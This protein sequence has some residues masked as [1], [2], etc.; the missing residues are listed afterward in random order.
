MTGLTYGLYILLVTEI[1]KLT[2]QELSDSV[3]EETQEKYQAMLQI[4]HE[5]INKRY[6]KA[7]ELLKST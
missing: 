4:F 3:V 5:N 7:T 6:T 1:L 2:V